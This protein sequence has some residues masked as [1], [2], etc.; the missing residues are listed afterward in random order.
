MDDDALLQLISSELRV[1][2]GVLLTETMV[3]MKVLK[4]R[5][6]WRGHGKDA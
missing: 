5:G 1:L 3:C 6:A 2:P 4:H